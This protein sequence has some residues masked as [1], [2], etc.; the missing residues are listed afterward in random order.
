MVVT[1]K[2]MRVKAS[3][4]GCRSSH[5]RQEMDCWKVPMSETWLK[6]C[7]TVFQPQI[8]KIQEA[9]PSLYSISIRKLTNIIL[10]DLR[11]EYEYKDNEWQFLAEKMLSHPFSQE[12]WKSELLYCSNCMIWTFCQEFL[13]YVTYFTSSPLIS[14]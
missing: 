11:I 12:K 13:S 14:V 4:S 6:Y 5:R 2:E 7:L 10:Y 8:K 3:F 1:I 9:S